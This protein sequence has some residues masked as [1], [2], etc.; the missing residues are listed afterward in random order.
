MFGFLRC[1]VILATSTGAAA[2]GHSVGGYDPSQL[3]AFVWIGQGMLATVNLGADTQL[4]T[5]IRTGEIVSDL[6]R[7]I[8]PIQAYFAADLGRAGFAFLTRFVTPVA[9]GMIAFDF[10][11]PR[12][13]VTYPLFAISLLIAV[14]LCFACKY[15]VNAWSYWLLDGRGPQ[16][17]WTLCATVLGGLYFPLRFLPGP[18]AAA[19]WLATPFPSLLQTPLDISVERTSSVAALGYIALQLVWLGLAFWAAYAVQHRGERRLVVNGG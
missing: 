19:L 18:V 15:V 6:L 5:R 10:Y 17:A 7:P 8:D 3:V 1:F 9:V 4:S 14:A 11:L 16:L 2:S 12:H 13:A